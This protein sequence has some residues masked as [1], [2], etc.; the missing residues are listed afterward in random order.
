MNIFQN[1][2]VSPKE[3]KKL[4]NECLFPVVLEDTVMMMS[5]T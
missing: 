2:N 3:H 1:M 4:R 5:S